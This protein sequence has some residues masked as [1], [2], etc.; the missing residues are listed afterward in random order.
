MATMSSQTGSFL[1]TGFIPMA[2]RGGSLLQE[3]RGIENT[4]A[5]FENA[6]ALGINYLE[7]DVHATG[8]GELVAF[9]DPDLSRV[10]DTPGLIAELSF[11][12][13][14]SRLVGGRERVPTLDELFETFPGA[15]FNIDMK[16]A[17][18]VQ[19]LA[20]TIARHNTGSRV[21]VGSFS[22][23]RLRS[24]RR[25]MPRVATAATTA[26]VLLMSAGRVARRVPG[27]DVVF[28]VP[29]THVRGPVTLTLVTP[30]TVAAVHAAGR[31]IHVWTIDDKDTMHRLIDLGVDGIITDR[32]DLLKG[33]LHTR[34]MWSTQQGT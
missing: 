18:A 28:Q 2:H 8:D 27:T 19:L 11:K 12:E 22:A 3:N 1:G 30:K 15:R 17:G 34:G 21:C 6:V 5:A 24:F 32:P 9:H 10:T 16:S 7:T 33:V 31:K 25:L 14:R 13:I 20:R 4:L 26:E 23:S 29:I